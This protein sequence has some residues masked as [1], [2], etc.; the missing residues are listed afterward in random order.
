MDERTV[1]YLPETKLNFAFTYLS[2][3]WIKAY[4]GPIVPPS[5][6]VNISTW[7]AK[8]SHAPFNKCLVRFTG[9]DGEKQI[10]DKMIGNAKKINHQ[11]NFLLCTHLDIQVLLKLTGINLVTDRCQGE[12]RRWVRGCYWHLKSNLVPSSFPLDNESGGIFEGRITGN[13][14]D[15][16]RTNLN[17]FV[18]D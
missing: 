2:L 16:K 12:W 6:N 8:V 9:R 4:N 10:S 1:H 7:S 18:G 13:E 14:V 15:L 11:T 17:T 3:V 5:L